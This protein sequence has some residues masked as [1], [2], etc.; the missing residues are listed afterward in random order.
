M[1]LVPS[2]EV[3]PR[4][5]SG[6]PVVPPGAGLSRPTGVLEAKRGRR[7]HGVCRLC[8]S[9]FQKRPNA[10]SEGS[11]ALLRG[12]SGDQ[13]A[14]R[15]GQ[16]DSALRGRHLPPSPR[17]RGSPGGPRDDSG[18]GRRSVDAECGPAGVGAPQP[19][20]ADAEH[21]DA[22]G[23]PS[24]ARRPSSSVPWERE[25]GA[26]GGPEDDGLLRDGVSLCHVTSA[27]Q[28]DLHISGESTRGDQA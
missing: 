1:R 11:L 8:R 21:R 26:T 5:S 14:W 9:L 23:P 19:E 2:P 6:F 27:I 4:A 28:R 17:R 18:G 15:G 20:D 16:D 22:L 3:E 13:A 7:W 25:R 24:L 10:P 12:G